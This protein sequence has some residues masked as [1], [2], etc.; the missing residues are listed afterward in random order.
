M[1]VF[2]KKYSNSVLATV[3]SFL[4]SA[5]A[6]SGFVFGI[7]EFLSGE[8]AQSDVEI[9]IG[10]AIAGVILSLF[11]KWLGERK[12]LKTLK[13]NVKEQNM[14]A[15]IRASTELAV[16]IYNKAPCKPVQKYITELNPAA[17]EII[18]QKKSSK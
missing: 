14:E 18:N 7:K 2:H 15:N 1:L 6:L 9:W 12:I 10:M 4:G 16:A 13:K 8:N 17:G 5:L 11:S 3:L